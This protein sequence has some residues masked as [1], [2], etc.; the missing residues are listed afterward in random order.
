MA[1]T[2]AVVRVHLAVDN[3]ARCS[4]VEVVL[5]IPE[6]EEVRNFLVVE[7]HH[8]RVVAEEDNHAAGLGPG[9]K[10]WWRSGDCD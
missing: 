3:L 5:R 1:R 2:Q 9:R 7:V 10:T 4:L 6:V 8:S